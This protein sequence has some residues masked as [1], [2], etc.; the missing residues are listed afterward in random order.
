[1][2]QLALS[3]P[4][5]MLVGLLTALALTALTHDDPRIRQ[6]AMEILETLSGGRAQ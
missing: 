6:I 5:F 2:N 1:M 4:S 3:A